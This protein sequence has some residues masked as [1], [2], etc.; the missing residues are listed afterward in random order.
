[1]SE[2]EEDKVRKGHKSV[3]RSMA[4]TRVELVGGVAAD[5]VVGVRK[6]SFL[7]LQFLIAMKWNILIL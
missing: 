4:L 2:V 7:T 6:N 1:M 3:T 5:G